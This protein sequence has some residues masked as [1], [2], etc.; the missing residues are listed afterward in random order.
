L[1]PERVLA[2]LPEGEQKRQAVVNQ[3]KQGS[4]RL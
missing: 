1:K 4:C 3:M 2:L